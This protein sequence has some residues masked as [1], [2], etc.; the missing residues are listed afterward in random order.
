MNKRRHEGCITSV[1]GIGSALMTGVDKS[2]VTQGQSRWQAPARSVTME[3][4]TLP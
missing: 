2:A 3:P 1:L 4:F